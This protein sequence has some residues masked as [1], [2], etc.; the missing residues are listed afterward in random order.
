MQEAAQA[1]LLQAYHAP[2]YSARLVL[3]VMQTVSDCVFCYAVPH[4]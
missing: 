4:C 1:Q 3:V 2:L